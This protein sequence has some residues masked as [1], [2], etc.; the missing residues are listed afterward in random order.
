MGKNRQTNVAVTAFL[1]ASLLLFGQTVS[2]AASTDDW[3]VI[4]HDASQTGF[5]TSTAPTSDLV[6]LWNY[7]IYPDTHAAPGVPVVADGRVYVGS[8]D[9]GVC[10]FDASDGTKVWGF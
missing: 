1:I 5:S 6:Q 9:Y 4:R 3:A 8:E 10:C 2:C 7:T